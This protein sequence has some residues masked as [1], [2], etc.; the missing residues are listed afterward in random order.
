MTKGKKVEGLRKWYMSAS[1]G[2]YRLRRERVSQRASRKWD[3][4]A[5]NARE[6]P[7][8]PLHILWSPDVELLDVEGVVILRF[9]CP[10]ERGQLALQAFAQGEV[11]LRGGEVESCGASIWRGERVL[12][13]DCVRTRSSVMAKTAVT[14]LSQHELVRASS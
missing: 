3:S 8:R 9:G 10:N 4:R 2:G 13:D 7:S 5:R 11:S 6:Q 12:K 1:G 14:H